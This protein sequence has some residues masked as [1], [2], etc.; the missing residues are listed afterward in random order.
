MQER[1]FTLIELFITLAVLSI[2]LTL[3]VPSFAKQIQNT[4][5]KTAALA[6][7]DAVNHARTLA[8]SNNKRAT[9]K[10]LGGGWLDGWEVF[11]DENNNGIRDNEEIT[12]YQTNAQVSVRIHSNQPL[13]NYVSFIGT[14]ESRYV[15]RANAGGFQ[16]GTFK[17]CPQENGEGHALILARSG[18][19]RME[20]LSAQECESS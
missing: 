12:V 3:G 11:I 16:A 2:L 4:R 20:K 1:G 7:L 8:V 10:P 13:N 5:T 6:L 9:L 15:G 19:M 17:V 14:G 18:R